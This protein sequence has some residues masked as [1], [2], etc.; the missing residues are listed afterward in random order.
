MKRFS[1]LALVLVLT[2]GLLA[3]CRSQSNTGT[4][5]TGNTNTPT[6]TVPQNTTVVPVPTPTP[7][8]SAPTT[9]MPTDG[10][11]EIIPGPED[12]IDPSNGAN[13][14]DTTTE[15]NET[16]GMHGE[17]GSGNGSGNGAAAGTNGKSF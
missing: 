1:I 5:N 17:T 10:M 9:I 3:G 7:E 14:D 8:S 6:N 13:K 16:N 15:T 2:L 11:D 4:S 12:M